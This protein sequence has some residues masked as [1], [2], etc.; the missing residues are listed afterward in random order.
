MVQDENEADSMPNNVDEHRSSDSAGRS[1]N[2]P[3]ISDAEAEELRE[4]VLH[5]LAEAEGPRGRPWYNLV[6]VG[7]VVGCGVFAAVTGASYGIGAPSEP[8]PGMWPF[9]LGLLTTGLALVIGV[10]FRRVQD[11]EKFSKG[12]FHVL[13][14][15]LSMLLFWF[16]LPLVGFEVPSILMCFVWLR[17]LGKE[18]W[19]VTVFATLGIV[20]AFYIVFIIAL[21]VPVPRLI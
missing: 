11:V 20:A 5:D 18:N 15:V 14:G 6:S 21:G 7:L 16:L 12:S 2:A 4:E 8:G 13:L 10:R 1:G 3:K 9:A 19:R 17:L